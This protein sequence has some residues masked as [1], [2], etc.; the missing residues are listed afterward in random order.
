M[1][2]QQPQPQQNQINQR[3]RKLGQYI[4]SSVLIIFLCI[5][6]FYWFEWRPHTGRIECAKE[7]LQQALADNHTNGDDKIH[8]DASFYNQVY[9]TCLRLKGLKP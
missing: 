5:G 8:Y 2:N 3:K 4:I 6:T 1:D 9:S 7:A